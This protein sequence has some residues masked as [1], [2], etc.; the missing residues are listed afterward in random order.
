MPNKNYINGRAHEYKV[1]DEYRARGFTV[2][3]SAGSHSPFDVYA[4]TPSG[5]PV[6][7]TRIVR[8]VEYTE[9]ITPITGYA[10]QCKRRKLSK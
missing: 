10:I 2:A 3:R 1:R 6:R 9:Y 7:T 4:V 5:D 8:G